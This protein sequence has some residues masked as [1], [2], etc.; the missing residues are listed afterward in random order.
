M[1][2]IFINTATPY[3]IF[4]GSRLLPQAGTYIAGVTKA[5]KVVVVTDT[6]VAPL[7]EKQLTASLK[8]A[9]LET[10]VC[11]LPS[12]EATKS[13]EALAGLYDFCCEF[14]LTRSDVLVALG[15]GVIGDLTGFCAATYM[16]GIDFIQIPTTFLAQ[17]DSSVGGKT[18]VNIPG[19][20]NLVGAFKQPKL[21]L[22]DVGTLDT[23]SEKDFAG[24]V[25]EAIKYGVIKDETIF[26]IIEE[27][28]LQ[29]NLLDVICRCIEIKKQVVEADEFDRGERMLLNFGHTF[30]HAVEK[31]YDYEGYSHGMAVAA[32]MVMM[33]RRSEQYGL[34]APGTAER[35]ARCVRENGLPDSAEIDDETLI[36]YSLMDKKASADSIHI[37]VAKHIG[38][39]AV[40][41]LSKNDYINFVKGTYRHDCT[42]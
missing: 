16:R 28:R 41:T 22:C 3:S 26:K 15:G 12:G 11:I 10:A 19:G 33:T 23:L 17:I 39:S 5:K 35:I 30:G 6:T 38:E 21:V 32:G 40:L 2:E 1:R 18:A 34:T 42:V 27:G 9:G 29:A 31:H 14:G 20:K 25:A 4:C 7:Y 37:I 24:G 13:L 36:R 8:L